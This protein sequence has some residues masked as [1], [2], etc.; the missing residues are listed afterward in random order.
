MVSPPYKTDLLIIWN[1]VGC[2]GGGSKRR[3]DVL[4]HFEV[5]GIIMMQKKTVK[6]LGEQ[7]YRK[8]IFVVYITVKK[9]EKTITTISR[10]TASRRRIMASIVKFKVLYVVR[11]WYEAIKN[12]K[13][14][15]RLEKVQRLMRIGI[16]S[17]YWT[18]SAEGVGIIARFHL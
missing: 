10:P 15:R 13:V 18:I 1:E 9:A 14:V 11:V 4:I 7:L 17:A 16:S 8:R 3:G 6:H 2:H 12:K 5:Q